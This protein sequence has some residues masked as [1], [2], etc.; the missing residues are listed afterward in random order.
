[1]IIT[2]KLKAIMKKNNI[3]LIGMMGSGKS[4]IGKALAEHLGYNFT[5][6]DTLIVEGEGIKIPEIFEKFGENYFRT[7]ETNALNSLFECENTVISTGGG[8]VEKKENIST[9]KKIGTVFYLQA[10]SNTLYER[11]K[12]DFNRPLLNN[13]VEFENILSRREK[14]YKEAN[15]IIDATGK[16]NEIVD[17][18]LI[19]R[20]L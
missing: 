17:E 20:K 3:I 15:F 8:I 5:D 18:I 13:T 10:P 16:I 6:L 9:L 19:K 12:G 14:T 1:M 7:I 11:I 4:T 2:N